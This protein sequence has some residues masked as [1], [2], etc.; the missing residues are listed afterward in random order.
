MTGFLATGLVLPM[1]D[2]SAS[3]VLGL[4]GSLFVLQI[5]QM[6]YAEF[7][8]PR[9]ITHIFFDSKG[10]HLRFKNGRL[11]PCTLSCPVMLPIGFL[12]H[13][14]TVFGRRYTVPVLRAMVS[15]HAFRRAYVWL[16]FYP[17]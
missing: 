16:K 10:Y 5:A 6:A 3:W 13:V 15:P 9:S 14:K 17:K 12:L 11:V 1:I 4:W 2:Q 7:V 8:K